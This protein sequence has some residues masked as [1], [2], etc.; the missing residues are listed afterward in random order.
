MAE[1][2]GDFG[3]FFVGFLIGGLA[4]AA[5]ALLLAP[6]SGEETRTIIRDKSIELKDRAMESAE[7]ARMRAEEVAEEA[8]HRAE[9]LAQ[10]ARTRAEEI[11]QKGKQVIDE[12]KHRIESAVEAGK[13]AAKEKRDEM[14]GE[15]PAT[16]V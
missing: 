12:Q 15:T 14:G 8:R 7:E 13:K 10:Q 11:Q 5:V 9:V 16:P 2:D 1:N 4:G 6:Q 3:T